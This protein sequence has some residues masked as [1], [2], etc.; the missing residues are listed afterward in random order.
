MTEPLLLGLQAY[1][2]V[3]LGRASDEEIAELKRRQAAEDDEE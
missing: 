1:G 2:D 3:E